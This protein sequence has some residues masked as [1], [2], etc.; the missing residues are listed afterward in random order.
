MLVKDLE[1]NDLH[2]NNSYKLLKSV[3][4]SKDKD[5]DKLL[6]SQRGWIR[7]RDNCE[8]EAAKWCGKEICIANNLSQELH[9]ANVM[10]AC[11]IAMTKNRTKKLGLYISNI[12]SK[13]PNNSFLTQIKAS[14]ITA[15]D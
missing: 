4:S 3:I 15:S 10:L 14:S 11:K 13:R 8:T 5:K 7:E 9:E 6:L 12:K 1:D 2:L